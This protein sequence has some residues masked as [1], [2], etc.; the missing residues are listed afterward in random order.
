MLPVDKKAV[1]ASGI[2]KPEDANKI[3]DTIYWD[4]NKNYLMKAD[5]MILD[6]IANN[7]WKRP[8]YFAVTVGSENYMNLE[9]YFQLE[10]LAY[11]FV[12][13]KIRE[14]LIQTDRR[15]EWT[16]TLCTIT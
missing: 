10:G 8:I 3:V 12:P 2:V 14:L 1:I 6:M 15:E 5:L 11:R 7:D 16:T 4:L 13:I 9:P